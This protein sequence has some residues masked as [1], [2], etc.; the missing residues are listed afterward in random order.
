LQGV[1]ATHVLQ[2]LFLQIQPANRMISVFN[3]S[4]ENTSDSDHRI[5][6]GFDKLYNTDEAERIT[7]YEASLIRYF[8]PRFNKEFRNSFPS[9]NMKVL[10]DCYQKDFNALVAEICFDELPFMLF[11]ETVPPKRYHIARHDLHSDQAR[12]LFFV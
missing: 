5:S 7:L 1:P 12:K 2:I 9:T 6:A 4:A 3:P 8:Q 10:A 11:T